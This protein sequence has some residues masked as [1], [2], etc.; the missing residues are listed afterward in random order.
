MYILKYE[1]HKHVFFLFFLSNVI[2][3]SGLSKIQLNENKTFFP[4][5]MSIKRCS[6]SAQE[7]KTWNIENINTMIIRFNLM[8]SLKWHKSINSVSNEALS[9]MLMTSKMSDN[10]LL[11]INKD[12]LHRFSVSRLSISFSQCY[13]DEL[14]W[15]RQVICSCFLFPA[16]NP[17]DVLAFF[18]SLGLW[19]FASHLSMKQIS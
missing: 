4:S 15:L 19:H 2:Q 8:C 3:C 16:E 14:I 1:W 10:L 7:H 12:Q 5:I 18:A 9:W 6:N 13:C 11:I 17:A